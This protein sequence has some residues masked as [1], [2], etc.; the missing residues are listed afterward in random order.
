M[1]GT[2]LAVRTALFPELEAELGRDITPWAGNGMLTPDAF[3]LVKGEGRKPAAPQ[4]PQRPAALLAVR[5]VRGA[6]RRLRSR[7]TDRRA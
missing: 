4:R 7:M 6:A 2:E 5:R 3:G 1:T